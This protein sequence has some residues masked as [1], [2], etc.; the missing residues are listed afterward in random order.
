[1]PTLKP[2]DPQRHAPPVQ[3]ECTQERISE[4]EVSN[5]CHPTCAFEQ[6]F[7]IAEQSLDVYE[8]RGDAVLAAKLP[9]QPWQRTTLLE[10]FISGFWQE[11]NIRWLLMLGAAIIFGS[12]LMLV[13]K[14]WS[15][16]SSF[17]RCLI[18][19]GYTSGF[20]AFGRF[21]SKRI[22]L[23][24]TGRVLQALT[25]V[26]LPVVFLSI[27]WSASMINMAGIAYSGS[28]LALLFPAIGLAWLAITRCLD[29][30]LRERQA[31]FAIAYVGLC[32]GCAFPA[33]SGVVTAASY[34]LVAW[35]L[36][37]AGAM[38]INRRI[39]RMIEEH[40]APRILGFVP[41]VLLCSIF[42]LI[43]V[44]KCLHGIPVEWIGMACLG[45]AVTILATARTIADVF[46]QRT[47]GI[48]RPLP[49]N[50]VGPLL[51]GATLIAMGVAF[52]FYGFRD[53]GT[54]TYA[55][56]PTSVF[57]AVLLFAV[58]KETRHS[59]FVWAGLILLLVGYQSTPTLIADTVAFI[60][61]GAASSLNEERLPIAFYG[62]T[63]LPI[64]LIAS[65][66]YRYFERR[67]NMLFSR[68]LQQLAS[69]LAVLLHGLSFMHFKAV[70]LVSCVNI[71]LFAFL[72]W[73]F[74]DRRFVIGSAMGLFV[75]N[76]LWVP[77]ANNVKGASWPLDWMFVSLV[78]LASSLMMVDSPLQRLI[79]RIPSWRD[80][81]SETS[82]LR[83]P[84]DPHPCPSPVR[85]EEGNRMFAPFRAGERKRMFLSVRT[86]EVGPH[87]RPY[88]RVSFRWVTS[89]MSW[90][91]R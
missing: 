43:F 42:L 37:S 27:Q 71:F 89:A 50:I 78:V 59:A 8:S 6:E 29:D 23:T 91:R 32:I 81:I 83:K 11:N 48:V 39:F 52:S 13:T 51:I 41:I 73:V 4:H 49:W 65:T 18:V 33:A 2:S 45:S 69:I 9:R 82:F 20:F 87:C 61:A 56:V 53:A 77:F 1:M 12:S 84:N 25:L 17:L 3:D 36:M 24:T 38:K 34:M 31:T 30:W 86:G 54:T 79:L 76:A 26:L 14:E 68:P 66:A 7:E 5:A 40:R 22:G 60:K 90:Q 44:T 85:T 62:L 63:Y 57:A 67:G 19:L 21:V 55:V 16:W 28:T 58:V 35:L 80:V 15:N 72:A 10:N 75:A 46:R 47:G 64:I 70:F 74:R 88:W